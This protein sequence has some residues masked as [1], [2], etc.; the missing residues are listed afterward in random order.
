ML[1]S[2]IP[3]APENGKLGLGDLR[4]PKGWTAETPVVL[5]IHGGGWT[6]G[7]R[8]S[9]KGVAEFFTDEL[10]FAS[11]NIEYRLVGEGC[12]WPSAGEDCVKAAKYLLGPEFAKTYG[13]KPEKL[14]ICGGSAGGHL[15]LWTGLSLPADKVAGLVSV[16][17]IGDPAPDRAGHPNRYRWM[18][19]DA[20]CDPRKLI[21]AGGPRIL[22]THA[23]GDK[24]VPIESARTFEADYLK[25]GNSV[26]FFAYPHDAVPNRGGHCIWR[27]EDVNG[28]KRLIKPVEDAIRRFV[29]GASASDKKVD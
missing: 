27:K 4:L 1:I 10:G 8:P 9:W 14:W 11:F 21:R 2:D 5:T 22:Q 29:R 25:A 17:G 13:L 16:S 20:G 24:V 28:G 18:G 6:S 3:Y 7:D 26:R 23:V 15:T 12:P 19:P